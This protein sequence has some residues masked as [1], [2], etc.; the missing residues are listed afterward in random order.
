MI[1]PKPGN[2]QNLYLILH[3]PHSRNFRDAGTDHSFL[4]GSKDLTLN[5]YHS[6]VHSDPDLSGIEDPTLREGPEYFLMD[7]IIWSRGAVKIERR[8]GFFHASILLSCPACLY[9]HGPNLSAR[10]CIGAL[11]L[12]PGENMACGIIGEKPLKGEDS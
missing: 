6:S 2:S 4:M 12:L 11:S 9:S 1:I 7:K 3:M 10:F 5:P 8:E